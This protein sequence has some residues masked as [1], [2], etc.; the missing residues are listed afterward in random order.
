MKKLLQPVSLL[1]CLCLFFNVSSIFSQTSCAGTIDVAAVYG[2]KADGVTDNYPALQRLN[3]DWRGADKCYVEFVFPAGQVNYSKSFWLDGIDSF[4][5]IGKNTN[6]VN[7]ANDAND[8]GNC[9]LNNSGLL[10]TGGRMTAGHRFKT[11]EKGS[12][13]ITLIDA[14]SYSVGDRIF[15]AGYEEQFY[16]Y[17]PNPRFFE[18][19]SVKAINGSVITLGKPLR[20]AYN[21]NWKDVANMLP[22]S[23]VTSFG[24][25][26]IY[27]INNYSRYA[28]FK[29][30]NFLRGPGVKSYTTSA[31]R[32]ISDVLICE[33]VY[34]EDF[35]PSENRVAIYTN[36]RSKT[37]E[38]DKMNE[39]VKIEGC[40]VSGGSAS[41]ITA[42]LTAATGVDSL[43]LIKNTFE[44]YCPLSP[45]IL[46]ASGNT[47]KSKTL[48]PPLYPHPEATWVEK[49]YLKDNVFFGGDKPYTST[50]YR[51]TKGSFTT[52]S[53]TSNSV[54]FSG[55][56]N[57]PAK[58][59]GH[60]EVVKSNDGATAIVT[61]IS[62]DGA[63]WLVNLGSIKG[64]LNT[65]QVW[66]F[67]TEE[68]VVD[69]CGNSSLDGK[70]IYPNQ[71]SPCAVSIAPQPPTL[72]L[73]SPSSG[74]SFTAPA[75]IN[76]TA[77][78]SDADGTIVKVEFFNGATKLGEDLSAPYSFSWSNVTSGNYTITAKAT[79]NGG[80]STIS[81]GINIS[82]NVSANIAPTAKLT[83]PT[84]GSNFTAPAILNLTTDASDADG[85]I[86]KVEFFN[87]ATKLGEDITAPYSFT[88]TDVSPGSYTITAKATDNGG[89]STTS[90]NANITVAVNVNLAP[91]LNL[92]SP[93]SGSSFTAPATINITADASDADG[94]IVKVEFFNGAT[95]LGEDLSAPYSFSWSNVT[96]GNY[97]ITAKAT[98]NGGLSTTSQNVDAT[99]STTDSVP[100]VSAPSACA[101]LGSI[102]Y[103]Y[104]DKVEWKGYLYIPQDKDPTS[105]KNLTSFS[106]PS[107][108]ADYYA[109]RIRGY[110]CP[111]QTGYYTFYLTADNLGELWLSTDENPNN[112]QSIASVKDWTNTNQ[113][114]KYSSQKSKP[115]YLETGRRYYVEAQYIEQNGGDHLSVAWDLPNQTSERPIKGEHLIPYTNVEAASRMKTGDMGQKVTLDKVDL[116]GQEQLKVYPNPFDN[117]ATIEFSLS[118]NSKVSLQIYNQHGAL[119]KTIYQGNI[120]GGLINR[121]SFK[122]SNLA[123]GVYICRLVSDKK[124]LQQQ[125]VHV[126]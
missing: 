99:V 75:T 56:N 6:F 113:Y 25:P 74:S 45:R 59:M 97:T 65:N 49:V 55:L 29:D 12:A 21:E 109:G 95:K 80:L 13:T 81:S 90:Q 72:N 51:W 33:N 98:D 4:K 8:M 105:T 37:F 76:I 93:S 117:E 42:S 36:C 84:T 94:T 121:Y 28:V 60:G 22:V 68:K 19:N 50:M 57:V 119:V 40:S 92:T 27:K 120:T 126:K 101:N 16:G 17:P 77:D 108:V 15:I 87:G 118:E 18:W 67:N 32:Y 23:D 111:P 34:A 39:F 63:N 70:M 5:V 58:L 9:P 104:W 85:T 41:P 102:T 110:I 91:T 71:T 116:Y 83:S 48:D 78:A 125:M 53:N 1:L 86:T 3:A 100:V 79:D 107:R 64:T 96:S 2:I 47:F 7:T 52:I 31:F 62:W 89:L 73:T 10:I 106:T 38:L 115:I 124:V 43:V 61:D 11:V 46:Y 66:N 44:N 24:K 103:E 112:K 123:S 26:R 30:C 54:T 82:V 14:A 35:W 114:E 88:W 122:A 20:W 69:L